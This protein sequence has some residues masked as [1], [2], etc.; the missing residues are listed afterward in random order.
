MANAAPAR[1]SLRIV[2]ALFFLALTV[3]AVT[4]PLIR[5]KF[6][7]AP[8]M[9]R[10][11]QGITGHTYLEVGATTPDVAAVFC[12][13]ADDIVRP[14]MR[15]DQPTLEVAGGRQVDNWPI[16]FSGIYRRIPSKTGDSDPSA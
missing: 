9:V 4:R 14:T 5:A 11:D 15:L 3:A 7:F 10:M 2:F 12:Y 1:I 6:N 13:V 8:D 16:V